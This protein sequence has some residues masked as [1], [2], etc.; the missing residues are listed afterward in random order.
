MNIR[1]SYDPKPIPDRRHDWSAWDDDTCSGDACD[2]GW[3]A[4]EQDAV[5]DLLEK[6]EARQPCPHGNVGA[7]EGCAKEYL[8]AA[9]R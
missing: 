1:T 5:S 8:D 9:T 2:F 3:G 4:N 6:I 7:C